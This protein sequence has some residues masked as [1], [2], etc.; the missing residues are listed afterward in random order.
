M[1]MPTPALFLDR[2]GVVNVEKNYVHRIEDFEFVE[3]I[4]DLC[5]VATTRGWPV[6]IVTNQAGI[7]RGLYTP[8]QF[9]LLTEWMLARFREEGAPLTAVYHC[10]YHPQHGVGEY[11]RESPDRKPGPGMILKARDDWNID[12]PRSA[13]LGD[14]LTDIEAAR[15]AGVGLR[16]LLGHDE[17]LAP[18]EI[19]VDSLAQAR[20]AVDGFW[21]PQTPAH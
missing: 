14:R 15:A 10:P 16:L 20:E 11:R 9:G 18:G 7:G 17:P 3:G 12:L 6:V 4:F 13:M 21:G 19:H 8:G 5:R 1:A 2:D